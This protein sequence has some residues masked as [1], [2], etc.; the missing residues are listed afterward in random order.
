MKKIIGLVLLLL[1]G[2]GYLIYRANAF[3]VPKDPVE[4][5]Q[6][7]TGLPAVDQ[8]KA[9]QKT[10]KAWINDPASMIPYPKGWRKTEV[11]VHKETFTVVT[12]DQTEPPQYYVSTE[13]PKKLIKKV[14]IARCLN[15][16]PKKITD[17]CAVGDNPQI[18]AYFKIIEWI[19]LNSSANGENLMEG[20]SPKMNIEIPNYENLGK[21]Q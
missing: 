3:S 4:A 19:K 6:K 9:F 21:S 11:T 8:A 16:D 7:I 20:I 13:F 10:A 14:T 15:L 5:Y 12:P 1:I 18:N 2:A 17:W